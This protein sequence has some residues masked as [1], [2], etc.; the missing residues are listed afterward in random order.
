[1]YLLSNYQLIS[2]RQENSRELI[3]ILI[4]INLNFNINS[5]SEFKPNDSYLHQLIVITH[6]IFSAFDGNPSLKVRGVSLDPSK[7]FNRVWHDGLFY[8]LKSNETKG[9]LFKLIEW[10]LNNRCQWVLSMVNLQSGNR[11]Q[12]LCREIQF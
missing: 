1:M 11:L 6:S 12:L 8:K 7:A 2:I 5:Q 10:F 3:L 9:N 4:L